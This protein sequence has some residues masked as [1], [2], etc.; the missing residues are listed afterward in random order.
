MMRRPFLAGSRPQL[1]QICELIYLRPAPSAKRAFVTLNAGKHIAKISQERSSTL[2]ATRL[3]A[4]SRPCLKAKRTQ[5][6]L[7]SLQQGRSAK[8]DKPADRYEK[9]AQSQPQDL[10]GLRELL[11]AVDRV[12]KAFLAQQG[13]PSEEMTL[14]ALRAVAQTDVKLALDAQEPTQSAGHDD[15]QSESTASHLL[16]LDQSARKVTGGAVAQQ[17]SPPRLQDVVDS[18][19]QA[20]YAIV[21]HPAVVITR[22]VL[23]EYVGIQARLGK[24]ET[25]PQILGLYATK[26]KPRLVSGSIH[27]VNRNANKSENA[28]EASVAEMALDSAIEAKNLDAAVGVV[29]STY[30][31]KA[32]LRSKLIRKA[33]LPASV[34]GATPIAAYLA[35]TNLSHFQDSMDQGTAT[36]IAFAGILAYVGFTATVG[37]VAAT[38][39]NDQMKR[40]TWA[41]GTP[42]R[43]RWIREEERAAFDKV[44]CS[45]GFSEEHR[46]GEEEGEAFQLLREYILRKGMVLDAVELMPGMN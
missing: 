32:F 22:Q 17:G 42:L 18:I 1:C 40:V 41:P 8:A 43:Q 9:P 21:S 28:I 36:K 12:T 29:E 13:I 7:R 25:L 14:A 16:D 5:Q 38:T 11:A 27:Y 4:T 10:V 45:F 46:Y 35:A 2:I 24:P 19:S 3:F 31:T 39:A 6:S 20:A 30:A 44:A 37:I 15:G 26:P 33:L 23:E 34:I